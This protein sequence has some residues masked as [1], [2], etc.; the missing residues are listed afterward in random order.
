M[1]MTCLASGLH[2]SSRADLA[3]RAAILVIVTAALVGCAN[4]QPRPPVTTEQVVQM[5][6]EGVPTAD[7]LQKMRDAGTVYRLSGSQLA[8][9]KAEGVADEVLD[10]MQDTYLAQTWQRGA[11]A[12]GS[13]WGGPWAWGPYPYGYWGPP[14]YWGP[15]PPYYPYPPYRPP[16]HARPPSGPPPPGAAP[17]AR[18]PRPISPPRSYRQQRN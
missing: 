5:S 9:L 4:V 6:K 1:K 13:Y 7:I 14:G 12:Y 17:P 2:C 18:P 3:R 10:Y 15:Y 11:Y 8:R 16:P